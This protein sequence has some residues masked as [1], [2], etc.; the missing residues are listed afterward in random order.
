MKK[1][2]RIYQ[3]RIVGSGQVMVPADLKRLHKQLLDFEHIDFIS[4]EMRAVVEE[5]WPEF[6]HKLPPKA[7]KG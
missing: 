3:P 7:P 6:V 4:D 2:R 5:E 1:K